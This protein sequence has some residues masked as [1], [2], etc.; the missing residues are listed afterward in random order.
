VDDFY[1]SYFAAVRAPDWHGRNLDALWDSLT[2][3]DINERNPPFRIRIRGTAQMSRGARDIVD[4]FE[5]LIQQARGTGIP[6][7]IELLP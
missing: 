2:G 7:E 5:N 1:A 6:V 3:R 4:R